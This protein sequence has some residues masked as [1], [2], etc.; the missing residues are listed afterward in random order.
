MTLALDQR[1]IAHRR[2]LAFARLAHALGMHVVPPMV[3]RRVSTGEL[4]AF[5]A[6]DANANVR[7]YLSAH[8]SIQNDGTIAA[9]VVAPSRGDASTAWNVI[10]RRDIAIDDAPEAR[11]W[12][13]AV[14]SAE[15]V[16]DENKIVLRDYV[17]ALVLDYLSANIMR[18]S[19]LLDDAA[20][21]LLATEND[22]AFP[23]KDFPNA[24]ARLLE[25]LK[26]VVRFPRSMFDALEK[27]DR[28]HAQ[29][30]FMRGPF[31][32]RLVSPRTLML[33]DERRATLLTLIA[34]RI[35]GYGEK[36]AL[37]L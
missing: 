16:P 5:F 12:A 4:G 17:E 30:V 35:G 37:S 18:R 21:G 36:T 10:P 23:S 3:V 24:E 15:P 7:A 32:T 6:N 2:P 1:P 33:I 11:A 13:R 19:L 9:L 27:F 26:P 14:A 25:R 20:T 29:E 34:A 31:E 8:A 22:G 28:V